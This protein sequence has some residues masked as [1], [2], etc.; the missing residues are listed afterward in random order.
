[1][2]TTGK[3]S[4]AVVV[5]GVMQASPVYDHTLYGEDFYHATL[6][7]P[8]LSGVVDELPLL[9]PG[10][11][12][13]L[14]V[15]G[16]RVCVHGQLRSY[17]KFTE[18]GSRLIITVFAR[19]L[20]LSDDEPKNQVA[21]QGYLCKPA[22]F[23]TT[24]FMREIADILLAVNRPYNKSDYLPCIAWGRNARFAQDIPVGTAL[25]VEGRLQ[26]RL[27]TKT[28]EDGTNYDRIAYEVS[29]SRLEERC[30]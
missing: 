5:C 13:V 24:P 4:N 7:V 18:S 29:C 3:D 30:L 10:R 20:E 26:S 25:H 22:V 17:K 11:R 2:C 28:L 23:R 8:R 27:Y 6:A 14:P 1:M 9:I 21:L 16:E 19:C 12:T 15:A